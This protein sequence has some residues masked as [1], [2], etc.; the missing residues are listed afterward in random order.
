MPTAA[1]LDRIER[2]TRLRAKRRGSRRGKP[3]RSLLAI[4]DLSPADVRALLAGGLA[5]KRDPSLL[6][7]ALAGRSV[8][9]LFQKTSTRTRCSFELGVGQMGG[10]P[11]FLDW[12]RSNFMLGELDD[13]TKVLSRY[14]DLIMARVYKHEDLV[15]MKAASEVP[16][17]NGLCDRHHPCQGLADYMTALEYFGALEG[18]KIA[19]VGDGNNVCHSLIEGA[20]R[21]GMEIAVAHPP[22][23]APRE[24]IVAAARALGPVTLTAD[25]REAV[26]G[27]DVVYTDT[28]VSMGDEAQKEAR[29]AAFAGYQVDEALMAHAPGHA[30]V[31]HCLPAHRGYEIS[32]GVMDSPNSVVF[33]QAENRLYLQKYLM[34]W[35]LE[36]A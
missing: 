32:S 25:P 12:Q 19:Y 30:L 17:V 31:M 4:A 35:I 2:S 3:E 33:D 5:V 22:G 20:V 11:L 27:A 7:R 16:I 6:A 13:E 8:A 9:L 24:D 14:F 29:L 21:V 36:A 26:A 15:A 34:A 28:W 23:Y 18:L 10:Q 1:E